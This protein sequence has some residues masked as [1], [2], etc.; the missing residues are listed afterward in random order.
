VFFAR[1]G[2]DV[3]AMDISEA[4]LEKV[5]RLADNARLPVR[6]LRANILDFRLTEMYDI[7]YSSGVLHYIK[8]HLRREIMENYKFHIN[9]NGLF[10][11]N[12]FVDKPFIAPPPEDEAKDAF[13]W[14][15]GELLTFFADWFVEDFS[16]YVFEC[17]SSGVAHK[18]AMNVGYFRNPLN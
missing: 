17:T 9:K 3:T 1:C 8:P 14:Q 16:E 18:H 6:T 2:Y 7:V 5:K 12:V 10:S 15:S 4:G 13:L 11:A